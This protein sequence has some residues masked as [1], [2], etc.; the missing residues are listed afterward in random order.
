ME[1]KTHIEGSDKRTV[2]KMMSGL[3][4]FRLDEQG[5]QVEATSTH[6]IPWSVLEAQCERRINL[7]RDN[8]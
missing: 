1:V 3:P 7:R 8:L 4:G 5:D 6:E 2:T